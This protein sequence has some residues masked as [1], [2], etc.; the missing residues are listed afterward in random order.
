VN[1]KSTQHLGVRVSPDL[2]VAL[3]A[4]AEAEDRSVSSVVRRSIVSALNVDA[5]VRN[6]PGGDAAQL[7]V[8]RG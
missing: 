8:A 5:D 3:R 7:E 4:R 6:G 2:V 1:T